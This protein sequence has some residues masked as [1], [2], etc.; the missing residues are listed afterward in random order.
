L[1]FEY[2]IEAFAIFEEKFIVIT[3]SNF[4][5]I[6]GFQTISKVILYQ[7][8]DLPH[9]LFIINRLKRIHASNLR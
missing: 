1:N 4:Y 9:N 5:L 3:L 6:K 8:T 2:A 7:V